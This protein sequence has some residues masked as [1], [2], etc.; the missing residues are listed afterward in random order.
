VKCDRVSHFYAGYCT[1]QILT[2]ANA[3]ER[4]KNTLHLLL[5]NGFA[6]ARVRDRGCANIAL[7]FFISLLFFMQTQMLPSTTR[8]KH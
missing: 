5:M 4:I 1:T 3:R 8:V 6:R 7:L 2:I